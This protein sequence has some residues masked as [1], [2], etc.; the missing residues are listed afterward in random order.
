MVLKD[1]M[2]TCRA[3]MIPSPPFIS[4]SIW[5]FKEVHF[6]IK[7]SVILLETFQCYVLLISVDT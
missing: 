7:R 6:F 3:M 5:I 1:L 4:H 2:K